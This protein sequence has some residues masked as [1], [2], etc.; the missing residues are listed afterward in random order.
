MDWVAEFMD[1]MPVVV[2]WGEAKM[3]HVQIFHVR[4]LDVPI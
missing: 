2:P 1:A 3:V 4:L